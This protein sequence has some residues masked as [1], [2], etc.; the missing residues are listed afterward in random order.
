M[1]TRLPIQVWRTVL[2]RYARRWIHAFYVLNFDRRSGIPV[3]PF[4]PENGSDSGRFDTIVPA[5]GSE[6]APEKAPVDCSTVYNYRVKSDK[7]GIIYFDVPKNA[8]STIKTLMFSVEHK[9]KYD[10]RYAMFIGGAL[11]WQRKFPG[12]V[13]RWSDIVDSPY[14]KFSFLRNPY[15]RLVSGYRNAGWRSHYEDASFEQ[16]VESLPKR[17]E[18]PPTDTYNNHYKPLRYFIPKSG[19]RFRL[20][21]IGKVENFADDFTSL[22]HACDIHIDVRSLSV[23][24]KSTRRHY[25]DYYTPRTRKIAEKIYGEDIELGKYVF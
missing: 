14:I 21:F 11:T 8:S 5:V 3:E 22:L 24:N 15:D 9:D 6:P 23:M 13:V 2:P 1:L 20:D 4:T 7:L 16:F 12:M 18:T 17:L 19:G 25:R 10:P